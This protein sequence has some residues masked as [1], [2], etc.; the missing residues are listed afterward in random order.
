MKTEGPLPWQIKS[1]TGPYR[2]LGEY[3]PS[4]HIYT[5]FYI[6]FNITLSSTPASHKWPIPVTFVN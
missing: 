3:N 6:H 2:D 1:N 5:F 4:P